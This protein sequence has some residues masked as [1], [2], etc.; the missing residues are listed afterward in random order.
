MTIPTEPSTGQPTASDKLLIFLLGIS[1]L[2]LAGKTTF[3]YLLSSVFA[4]HVQLFLQG[5][6]FCKDIS[7]IPTCNGYI[8]ANGPKG[9]DF[10]NLVKMLDYVKAHGGKPPDSLKSWQYDVYLDQKVKALRMVPKNTLK[11]MHKK[12][13]K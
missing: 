5:N 8:N 1:G 9:V 6:D 11:Q 4:P 13:S 2:S 10:E 12:V 3:A 7:L